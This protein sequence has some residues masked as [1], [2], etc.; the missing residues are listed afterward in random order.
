MNLLQVNIIMRMPKPLYSSLVQL[1]KQSKLTMD[2]IA[3]HR[4]KLADDPKVKSINTRLV[5]DIFHCVP[6]EPRTKFYD[7]CYALDLK[8]EHITSGLLK[9]AKESG[10]I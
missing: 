6:T 2:K 9:A 8:D 5:W 4:K 7:E 1:L 10:Y 3:D